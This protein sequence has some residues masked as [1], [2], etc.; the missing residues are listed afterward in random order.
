MSYFISF[1][2]HLILLVIQRS[3]SHAAA[4]VSNAHTYRLLIV[5]ELVRYY[6]QH[7]DKAF[8]LSAA[9]K[10]DYEAFSLFRQLLFFPTGIF[11]CRPVA[12]QLLHFAAALRGGEL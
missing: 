3:L 5:K 8:C 9:K 1:C 6:L 10:E 11:L 12:L 7:V 2:E 4:P